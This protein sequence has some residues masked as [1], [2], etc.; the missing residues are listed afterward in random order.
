MRDS[1]AGMSHQFQ[2][3]NDFVVVS[4]R[5]SPTRRVEVPGPRRIGDRR[6]ALCAM[7]LERF[8]DLAADAHDRV[9]RRARLLEYVTHHPAA[10]LTQLGRRHLQHI[11]SIQPDLAADVSGRRRGHEPRDGQRRDALA[12]AA[13]AHQTHRF[14]RFNRERHIIHGAHAGS[15]IAGDKVE[16]QMLNF[17]QRHRASIKTPGNDGESIIRP[18]GGAQPDST[19]KRLARTGLEFR[20]QPAL[21][22]PAAKTA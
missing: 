9:E 5:R 11:A 7:Q 16:F 14:T 13:F 2:Q 12:A 4:E 3:A 21:L 18:P 19:T 20:L 8:L 22:Q 15:F 1:G 6:S 10:N 17:Q